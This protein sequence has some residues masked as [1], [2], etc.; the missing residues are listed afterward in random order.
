MQLTNKTKKGSFYREAGNRFF[1]E[2]EGKP[3]ELKYTL[4]QNAKYKAH[5]EEEKEELEICKKITDLTEVIQKRL[6][7]SID[8]SAK[9]LE[10]ALNPKKDVID[11]SRNEVLEIF[12]ENVDLLKIVAHTWVDKKIFNPALDTVLDPHLA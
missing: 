11:Y 9:L 7:R 6:D 12:E 1:L 4:S 8:N 3:V 10:I 2:I 5:V